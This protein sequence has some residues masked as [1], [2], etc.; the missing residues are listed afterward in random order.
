MAKAK[1][2]RRP[3]PAQQAKEPTTHQLRQEYYKAREESKALEE[4]G[5]R[6]GERPRPKGDANPYG[7]ARDSLDRLEIIH[8][9]WRWT[10]LTGYAPEPEDW[11]PQE[12]W[13]PAEEVAA[14]FG[15]WDKML[16]ASGIDDAV[17]AELADKVLAA[18]AELTSRSAAQS[19]A[20]KRLEE[21][22]KRIPEVHRQAEVAKA[23][24]EEA[25]AARQAAEGARD[26]AERQRDAL[27]ARVAALEG[28]LAALKA[29]ADAAPAAA[30]AEAEV[31]EEMEAALAAH[32][33]TSQA[34]DELHEH[35]ERLRAQREQ[36]HRA[37][38]ELTRL[39]A[40][41]DAAG[42]TEAESAAPEEPPVTVLEAVERAA[43]E[44]RHLRYAPRAFETAGESP[45]RRP[46]LVLKTLRA[47]DDLA[48]RFAEGD[49]GKSLTQAASEH[50][51][52]QWK[53]DVSETTRK[54]YEDDYTFTLDGK[55]LWVGPHI[56]LGSGSGAGF[57]ARIYLH[58][59][60]GGEV[61]RGITVAVVGR[62]LPDTT[63]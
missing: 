32:A 56:G 45:F 12:G 11:D 63:T 4:L 10:G 55:R 41:I 9:V 59:S 36:D 31:L 39:L 47:L 46:G 48:G 7:D 13:P 60:D 38:A 58:V 61:P 5:V 20:E 49:M 50:G 25:D 53:Q 19:I 6:L 23:K 37:I 18:H 24:R 17:F 57:V 15:S 21:E 35:V 3:R 54:R 16:D 43:G 8:S 22:S 30:P 2:P 44:A 28:E 51:I 26:A 40:G 62:H 29:A 27:S 34:R 33:R 14:L 42:E 52:T 1:K